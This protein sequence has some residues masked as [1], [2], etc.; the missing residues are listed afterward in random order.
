MKISPKLYEENEEPN[1]DFEISEFKSENY[2]T[3]IYKILLL[4]ASYFTVA[5]EL[6][7]IAGEKYKKSF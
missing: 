3:V 2:L 6:R 5:T 4:S 7:L 1:G